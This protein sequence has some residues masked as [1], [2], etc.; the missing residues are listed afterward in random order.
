VQHHWGGTGLVLR[1]VR[2]A[3]SDGRYYVRPV[4]QVLTA[5]CVEGSS[6]NCVSVLRQ[7]YE[8]EANDKGTKEHAV[9]CSVKNMVVPCVQGTTS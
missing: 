9:E 2:L 7:A 1:P 3:G 6:Q 5:S 4:H 8:D